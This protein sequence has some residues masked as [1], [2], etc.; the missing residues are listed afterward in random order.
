MI[1]SELQ[2][3]EAE[4]EPLRGDAMVFHDTFLGIT[5]KPLQPIDAYPSAVPLIEVNIA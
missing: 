2:F 3:L 1:V 5:P 4:G